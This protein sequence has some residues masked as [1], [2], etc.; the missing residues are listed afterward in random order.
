MRCGFKIAKG[1]PAIS[2]HGPR[3]PFPPILGSS[4]GSSSLD[5]VLS[6]VKMTLAA[7]KVLTAKCHK[8]LL[9]VLSALTAKLSPLPL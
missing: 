9:A 3:T 6:E 5:A 1:E 7:E 8:D 4:A 2:G